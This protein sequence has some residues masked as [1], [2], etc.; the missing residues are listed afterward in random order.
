LDIIRELR[1]LRS[2][3]DISRIM[4]S[5]GFFL[6]Y[7]YIKGLNSDDKM[8]V[9]FRLSE[10]FDQVFIDSSYWQIIYD[11]MDTHPL[12]INEIDTFYVKFG[13]QVKNYIC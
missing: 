4:K 9:I 8:D 5:I 11:S 7:D 6:D 2:L 13:F 12:K 3:C 10:S 1:N